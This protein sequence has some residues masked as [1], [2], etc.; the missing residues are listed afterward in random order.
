MDSGKHAPPVALERVQ[1]KIG[2]VS[3]TF[4]GTNETSRLEIGVG[5]DTAG[6]VIGG[7][8]A[9]GAVVLKNRPIAKMRP[10]H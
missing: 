6:L 8:A 1:Y 3:A 7:G 9:A 5:K 4:T 10:A 2:P